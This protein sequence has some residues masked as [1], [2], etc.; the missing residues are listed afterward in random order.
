MAKTNWIH[1]VLT[2]LNIVPLATPIVYY[3]NVSDDYLVKYSVLNARIK[4]V[5]IELRIKSRVDSWY[6]E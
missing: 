3:D 5:E 2:E 6:N 4:Y 1:K